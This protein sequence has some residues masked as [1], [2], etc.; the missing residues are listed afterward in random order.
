MKNPAASV[1]AR[2]AQRRAKTGE[3]FNVLLVR[4]SLE[5]LLYRLSRST[6]REQ[7]VLKGAML[8]A[9]WEPTL[10]RVTRDLDLLGFGNPSR[11]RLTEIF[12][13]LSRMKVEADGVDFDA[14]SITTAEIRAQDE[15]AGIRVRLKA[16]IGNA[17]VPLQVDVGSG[18]AL[19]VT[20]EEITFPVLL[21]MDAPKLRAYSRET[22][23]AEKLQAL[24]EWGML[25]TRFKDYFDLHFLAHKFNFDGAAL[26]TSI[27]TTF[28]RR[29]T[30][31]PDGLPVGLTP[32]FAQDPAKIRGWEAFWRKTV[33]KAAVPGLEAIVQQLVE[34]LE[35][36]LAA[37][38]KG[39]SLR[40]NWKSKRWMES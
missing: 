19:S 39:M 36:P 20:P 23:I 29:G 25:N 13:E 12:R 33:S 2:L 11:G 5:R 3:D 6:Y 1:H 32:T 16:H 40:K 7:F 28:E 4:F 38:A 8:F 27:A 31:F 22:V 37:A 30:P 9:L 26:S 10:H 18:D 14:N 15:Y 34:F 21:G 17:V 24:V 35:P